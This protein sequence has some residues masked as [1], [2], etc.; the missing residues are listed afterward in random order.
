MESKFKVT[1]KKK[2]EDER[3]YYFSFSLDRDNN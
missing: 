1:A 2:V 3:E